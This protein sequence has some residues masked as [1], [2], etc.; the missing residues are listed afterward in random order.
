MKL[1]TRSA[2]VK[3]TAKYKDI[4]KAEPVNPSRVG[5]D[6]KLLRGYEKAQDE[7]V[8][9]GI[10]PGWAS[11]V[12]RRGQI[13]QSGYGGHSDVEKKTPFD[14]NTICRMV[15]ATKTIVSTAFFSL[16]D[17]GKASPD[18]YLHKYIPAFA[19]VRVRVKDSTTKTEAQKKPIQL[20]DL[21][22]HTSGIQYPCDEGEKPNNADEKAYVQLRKSMAARKIPNLKSFV[23]RLA[24]IPLCCQPGT[25]YNY[26]YSYD[27]LLR[28]LEIIEGKSADKVLQERVFD[29]LGMKDT[30]YHVEEKDLG[31]LSA[32]YVDKQT[33][34]RTH[35][36]RKASIPHKGMYRYDGNTDKNFCMYR[37]GNQCKVL[38]GGGF[39]GYKVGSGLV[40]TVA[41][42]LLFVWMLYNRGLAANGRRLLKASTVKSMEINRCKKEYNP[43]DRACYL[44]NVGVFRDGAD[45]IGMGGAACTYWNI[46]RED[47]TATI[48]FTQSMAM[49][50]FGEKKKMKGVDPKKAD[51]WALLHESIK[52]S[53]KKAPKSALGK[54]KASG[55][56]RSSSSSS[57]RLKASK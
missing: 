2:F 11:V 16:V 27:V 6:A 35:G 46:D 37:K 50:D 53:S 15:C 7:M 36:K 48:W 47:D 17:E 43:S 38:S 5:L 23:A 45:E 3:Q 22:V 42:H 33:F 32:C 54:R 30:K 12:I 41:D 21:M 40:S 18:D 39:F 52:K 20:K 4:L 49:P 44:G 55:S 56:A 24:K 51:L 19:K 29:P 26:S 31:R 8:A 28:V 25:V 14:F 10:I 9:K 1:K 13:V 57:K 34:E